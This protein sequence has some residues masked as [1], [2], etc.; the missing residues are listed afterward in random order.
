[1]NAGLIAHALGGRKSGRGWTAR[2]PAH[3]DRTPS[4]SVSEAYDG[5]V[6]V[7]CHAGCDQDKVISRLRALG[8]WPENRSDWPRRSPCN[9][10]VHARSNGSDV[11]RSNAALAIW[12]S[13][14][15]A[16][17]TLADTYLASR[18]I[19]LLPPDSL[20]FHVGLRHPSGNI[21]PAII[22][23]VTSGATGVPIGIHR[24]F[25]ARDG[26][27]KALVEPAKMMLG[28]CRGGAVRLAPVRDQLMIAEGLET[29]LSAMQAT[30]LA[31][32]AALSTSGLR[33]LELPADVRNVVV[34]ADG[35]EAGEAAAQEA[36]RRWN[37][38]GRRVRIARPPRGL[39]FNDVLA[40]RAA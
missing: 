8:L 35:D 26:R 18:S 16:R 38:Q 1:M 7:R 36:A 32:W 4:L 15:P 27:G 28:P 25:L 34:L 14:Q 30:G 2:C 13:A 33:A 6:L 31:T 20:R 23:L 19:D 12:K 40:G 21:W 5:K 10:A 11:D 22:A 37:N 17:G 3:D 39:D 9:L 29:A 24:T